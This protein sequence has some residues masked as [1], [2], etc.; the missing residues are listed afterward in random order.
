MLDA[1][2]VEENARGPVMLHAVFTSASPPPPNMPCSYA[3]WW[4]ID[5]ISGANIGG[6][7]PSHPSTAPPFGCFSLV[8]QLTQACNYTPSWQTGVS[9]AAS[10]CH[11]DGASASPGHRCCHQQVSITKVAFILF[12]MLASKLYKGFQLTKYQMLH[13]AQRRSCH[14]AMEPTQRRVPPTRR[15]AK[16]DDAAAASPARAAEPYPQSEAGGG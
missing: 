10:L 14:A 1:H 16:S 3:I 15:Q 9:P 2:C 13:A 7:C 11:V 8:R 4:S 12:S 6:S 5:C